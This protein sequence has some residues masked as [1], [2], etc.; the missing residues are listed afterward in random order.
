MS[1]WLCVLLCC[2]ALGAFAQC[3]SVETPIGSFISN[4]EADSPSIGLLGIPYAKPMSKETRW[5]VANKEQDYRAGK[6]IDARQ[7]GFRCPQMALIGGSKIPTNENCLF[8]NIWMPTNLLQATDTSFKLAERDLLPVMVFIHGGGFSIGSG[9]DPYIK[10]A[11]F[12]N[13]GAILVSFNYRLGVLGFLS[14]EE[15]EQEDPNAQNLGLLDQRLAISWIIDNIRHFGGD[16][17][18]LTLFGESAGAMSIIWHLTA[19]ETTIPED[20]HILNNIKG[21]IIQSAPNLDSN[22]CHEYHQQAKD[23]LSV[24]NCDEYTGSKY[25]KCLREVDSSE[26]ETAIPG[27]FFGTRRIFWHTRREDA[28]FTGSPCIDNKVFNRHPRHAFE[29]G[30]HD[31]HTNI[32]IGTCRDEGTLFSWLSFLFHSKL[33]P[34][35]LEAFIHSAFFDDDED[36]D[37]VKIVNQYLQSHNETDA[38]AVLSEIFNDV[39]FQCGNKGFADQ[40]SSHNSANVYRYVFDHLPSSG[41]Q[42]LGVYHAAELVYIFGEPVGGGLFPDSFTEEETQLSKQINKYWSNFATYGSPMGNEGNELPNWPKYDA[43]TKQTQL[44][45]INTETVEDYKSEI[46][47]FWETLYPK[48]IPFLG[49]SN[50]MDHEA[51]D[52]YVI[53]ETGFFLLRNYKAAGAVFLFAFVTLFATCVCCCSRRSKK[54]KPKEE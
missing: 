25:L 3:I 41:I 1:S 34:E 29:N 33:H 24:L 23:T 50:E 39:Y 51:W 54:Q 28:V 18:N 35:T 32:I 15:I 42:T 49:T 43:V 44:L 37:A 9:D 47:E 8:L 13:N 2:T 22:Y 16:P 30:H 31:V 20:L 40:L 11:E 12:N 45:R 36:D 17:N 26:L 52:S 4:S 21:A 53:N 46:C 38:S 5:K 10:S 27:F 48:G 7:F 6:I 14:L 19:D